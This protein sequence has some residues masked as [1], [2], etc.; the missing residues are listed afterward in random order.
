MGRLCTNLD[1]CRGVVNSCSIVEREAFGTD[2]IFVAMVG[3]VLGGLSE[4][5]HK[6][7]GSLQLVVGDD[8]EEGKKSPPDGTEVVVGWFPSKRGK[9]S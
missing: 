6:G 5:G 1:D 4:D 7:M 9:V 2:K 8:H 3:F